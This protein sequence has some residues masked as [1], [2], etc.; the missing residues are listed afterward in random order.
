MD[1]TLTPKQHH[2][3]IEYLKDRNGKAAA[4]RA[5]YSPNAAAQQAYELLK[6]PKIR[7]VVDAEQQDSLDRVRVDRDWI[8]ERL[9]IEAEEAETD[10]ARVRALELLG[11]EHG[12]FVERKKVSHSHEHTFFANV[13]LNEPE[14]IEAEF[15]EVERKALPSPDWDLGD[16]DCPL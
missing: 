16:E 10:G 12:M 8:I 15:T 13:D 5:G 2:F 9:K 14:A 6:Q 3:C 1:D 11:K 7:A 4:I